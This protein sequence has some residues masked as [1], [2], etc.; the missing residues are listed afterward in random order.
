MR[1]AFVALGMA[2]NMNP[3]HPGEWHP[4]WKKFA[5][6]SQVV[7][8][9]C[10]MY[11]LDVSGMIFLLKVKHGVSKWRRWMKLKAQRH[12]AVKA[13]TSRRGGG[14]MFKTAQVVPYPARAEQIWAAWLELELLGPTIL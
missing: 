14:K 9:N 5:G 13:T 7:T 6:E 12:R 1:Q 10:V 3:S 4:K 2:L 11:T 8:S